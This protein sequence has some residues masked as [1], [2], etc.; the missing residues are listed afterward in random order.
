MR[1]T[2]ALAG[3]VSFVMA[4]LGTLLA[5]ALALPAVVGAQEARIRAEQFTLVGE[6]GA[7][8]IR[9]QTVPG[10]AAR[11]QVL[12]A[13]GGNR[14]T[15]ATGG[16]R[17]DNPNGAGVTLLTPDGVP[18]GRLGMG[19]PDMADEGIVNLRLRDRARRDRLVLRV[20]E[21]GAPSIELRDANGNVTWSAR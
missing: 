5:L 10:I 4:F 18:V 7:D 14:V 9:L 1:R 13:T 3:L 21:D 11:V 2:I 6:N 15:I 17:G 12:D 16:P 19:D 20:D 8:R